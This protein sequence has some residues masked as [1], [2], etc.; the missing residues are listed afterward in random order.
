MRLIITSNRVSANTLEKLGKTLHGSRGRR[1][2][3][4]L[5]PDFQ[6][7]TTRKT[8][9]AHLTQPDLL[10]SRLYK[11]KY[12]HSSN[13]LAA[14]KWSRPS[15]G[16]QRI[17]HG[18]DLLLPGLLIQLG[19]HSRMPIIER[20]SVPRSFGPALPVARVPSSQIRH[21]QISS[22]IRNGTWNKPLLMDLFDV[23]SVQ[24][25]ESITLPITLQEDKLVWFLLA[26]GQY[27]TSSRYSFA[28]GLKPTKDPTSV[29]APMHPTV[30]RAVWSLR[31][32]PKL[33]F[34]LWRLCHRIL[35]TIDG[36][37]RRGME[38]PAL[39]PVC[40]RQ[41]ETLEHLLFICTVTR[42][43][44]ATISLDL[45]AIPHTHPAIA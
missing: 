20:A 17:L 6:S 25:I 30:W 15:N 37:N 42:R 2:R 45:Y 18:R 1:L 24:A 26:N 5:I 19:T 14:K 38:L 31:V 28:M 23:D 40:M 35:P 39:C 21:L 27:S 44:F 4:P 12:F 3:L 9:L 43:F 8:K 10:I 34:F 11:G 41:D 29:V 13:F 32:Q 22:L 36:L 33:R 16:W 7:S